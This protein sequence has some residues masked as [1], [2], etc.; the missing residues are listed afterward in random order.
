[1]KNQHAMTVL[2]LVNLGF[3]IFLCC[4]I[5][6]GPLRRVAGVF[7]QTPVRLAVNRA[8]PIS[9]TLGIAGYFYEVDRD[10]ASLALPR[11]SAGGGRG[12]LATLNC[13]QCGSLGV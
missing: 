6:T 5:R 10:N 3:V 12:H 4:C 13:S 9:K 2:T 7:N 8:P 11:R 1:M